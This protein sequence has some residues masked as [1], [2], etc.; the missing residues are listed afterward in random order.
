MQWTC[1][2]ICC[3]LVNMFVNIAGCPK[4][5]LC[6]STDWKE[7]N[8]PDWWWFVSWSTGTTSKEWS[9]EI[10][11]LIFK[12]SKSRRCGM[13]WDNGELYEKEILE[14]LKK[15]RQ[16]YVS[17]DFTIVRLMYV[18]ALTIQTNT[19]SREFLVNGQAVIKLFFRELHTPRQQLEAI[20]NLI[21]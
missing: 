1:F 11:W 3:G 20:V 2:I 17:N 15:E 10:R 5:D 16:R 8:E 18:Y 21:F 9:K 4:A 12:E 7:E 13:D 19:L 14:T 6:F